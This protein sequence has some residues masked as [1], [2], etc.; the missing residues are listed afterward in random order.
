MY[1]LRITTV[2][3]SEDLS[4]HHHNK[5]EFLSILGPLSL[6][7][8]FSSFFLSYRVLFRTHKYLES[9]DLLK[10]VNVGLSFNEPLY[11]LPMDDLKLS[12]YLLK[13][14]AFT[15]ISSKRENSLLQN[16]FSITH[17]LHKR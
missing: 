14:Y 10:F 7:T 15:S 5:P 1:R 4:R 8:S 2:G 9:V 12:I 13:L 11:C 6:Q 17:F 3:A 16:L